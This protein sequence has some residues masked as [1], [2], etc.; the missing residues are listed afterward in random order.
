MNTYLLAAQA[1]DGEFDMDSDD[2]E[3]DENNAEEV[4]I[5]AKH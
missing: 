1:E 3:D 5:K 2:D 4:L